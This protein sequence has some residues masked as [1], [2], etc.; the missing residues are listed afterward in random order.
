MYKVSPKFIVIT[1]KYKFDRQKEI[2]LASIGTREAQGRPP[3]K[4]N[5]Y[6]RGLRELALPP[7]PAPHHARN[8]MP[9]SKHL[10]SWEVFPKSGYPR[11]FLLEEK[12]KNKSG[13]DPVLGRLWW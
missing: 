7:P 4:K 2:L 10:F 9:E 6:F 12:K 3:M 8:A 1:R 11:N 5:V 13:R